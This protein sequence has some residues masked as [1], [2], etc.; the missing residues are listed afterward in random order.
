MIYLRIFL[1]LWIVHSTI[2]GYGQDSLI[3]TSPDQAKIITSDILHFWT[4][5]D[6]AFS[7]YKENPFNRY[8][9]QNGSEGVKN[10]MNHDRIVSA[11]TLL[12]TVVRRKADYL[13]I[14]ENSLQIHTTEK[15]I[16][17]IYYAFK[18]LYPNAKFPP[19]YFVIGRFNTGG[20]ITPTAQIIGAEMNHPSNIPYTVAH[21]LIHANQNIPYKDSILLEQ[22]IIEGSADFLGE[23]ISGRLST[24]APYEYAKGK[25]KMLWQDFKKDINLGE[26]DSFSNWLYGGER[27]DA[28]PADMG[29]YIGYMIT[30]A[31]YDKASDKMK[32]IDEILNIQD[33]RKFLEESGYGA[34]FENNNSVSVQKNTISDTTAVVFACSTCKPNNKIVIRGVENKIITNPKFP[35]TLYLKPGEYNM[36]YVQNKIQQINLP[37]VVDRGEVNT[38]KVK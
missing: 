9:I 30:K 4:A 2:N 25:E 6:R 16:K 21:E 5:F 20:T 19:V 11:D 13:K 38:I 32:A 36:T 24:T 29:Y 35:L 37:F 3:A 18:Y 12:A 22:C 8:Y 27:K 10:F 7:A 17:A 1:T 26:N 33:C 34:Q 15:Q 14:R 31:Y 23:L 28:R